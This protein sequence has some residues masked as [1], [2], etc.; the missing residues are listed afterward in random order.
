MFGYS[1]LEENRDD[2]RGLAIDGVEPTY[3][4]IADGR[5]PGSR[6][7]YLYVKQ[8]HL[9]A[10]PGLRMFLKLYAANWGPDGPLVRR[11]LIAA[12]QAVRDA[13]AQVIARETPLDPATLK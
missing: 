9:D 7:L 2:A 4:A 8:A 5:Y 10:V 3:E 6:P 13:A 1:Y 12:P 11:G